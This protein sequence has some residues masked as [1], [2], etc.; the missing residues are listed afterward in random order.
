ML[1]WIATSFSVW[2]IVREFWSVYKKPSKDEQAPNPEPR[3]VWW[4]YVWLCAAGAAVFAYTPVR[5]GLFERKL[6]RIAT[7]LAEGRR[8]KVHCNT[9]AD[10]LFDPMV[11]AAG[12]ANIETGQIVLQHPW[13]GNLMDYIASPERAG[14]RELAALNI[15]THE[16][17]HVRGER[18][19]ALTECQAVQRNYRTAK[20]L[21]VRDDLAGK[22]AQAYFN[23]VYQMRGDIG[24]MAGVYYS[25]DCKPGGAMDEKLVDSTWRQSQ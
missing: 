4:A 17:M 15:L 20:L 3:K 18:N 21:G 5:Y 19:E 8:A 11:F 6:E 16:A 25:P 12:H 1:W 10:T 7:E 24:G 14:H 2:L 23:T 9:V 22:T 13:C